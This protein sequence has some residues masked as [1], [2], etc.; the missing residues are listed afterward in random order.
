MDLAVYNYICPHCKHSL[1][2]NKRVVLKIKR[3][4]NETATIYLNPKPFE[5]DY[6]TD[7]PLTLNENEEVTFYCPHCDKDLSSEE[8]NKFVKILMVV[9][10]KLEVDVFF[11]KIYGIHKTYVGIEDFM[12]E[13][14]EE[15]KKLNAL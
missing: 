7:P 14:G 5:Y 3:K 2:K 4:N 10:D 8:Y 9:A 13:Y 15:I 1:N 6:T 12:D 11:S